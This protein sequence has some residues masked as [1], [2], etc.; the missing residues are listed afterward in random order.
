LKP[1]IAIDTSIAPDLPMVNGD[2]S[3]LGQTLFNLLDNATKYAGDGPIAVYAK[4]DGPE[5]AI[6]ITDQGRGIPPKDLDKIFDKFYRR[7]KGDGRAPGTGLGLS[8]S[9]GFIES[10]GGTIK[11]ESP[12]IRKRGTRFIIRLPVANPDDKAIA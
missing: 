6:S 10:M 1:G 5:V 8:I 3:L 4:Q 7:V 12:A 9:R 11:A 2:A